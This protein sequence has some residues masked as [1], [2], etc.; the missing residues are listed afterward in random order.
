MLKFS[1]KQKIF[2]GY[3]ILI[4]IILALGLAAFL[5]IQR[6]F[7]I[8]ENL[9][10]Q[11]RGIA[12]LY[13]LEAHLGLLSSE[14]SARGTT[15][16]KSSFEKLSD[17]F[18]SAKHAF[19][20]YEAINCSA[21]SADVLPKIDEMTADVNKEM[22]ELSVEFARLSSLFGANQADSLAPTIQKMIEIIDDVTETDIGELIEFQDQVIQSAQKNQQSIIG[23][24][25]LFIIF[26]I[27]AGLIAGILI[28][29]LI[30][31]SVGRLLSQSLDRLIEATGALIHS[32]GSS[33][34]LSQQNMSLASEIAQGADRQAKEAGEI[35]KAMSQMASAIHQASEATQEVSQ[36]ATRT[37]QMA[38]I[39]GEAGEKS[40]RSLVKIRDIVSASSGMIKNLSARS[41]EIASIM[42][43][44]TNIAEQTNLLALNAAIEAARAGDA[45]RG[46]AVVADEVRKL[47]EEAQKSS[48]QIKAVIKNMQEQISDIVQSV[49]T[50]AKE[51]DVGAGVID[52]TLNTLQSITSAIQQVSSKIQ[53]ISASSQQQASSS[54]QVSKTMES[55]VAIIDKNSWTSNEMKRSAEDQT[56]L[57]QNVQLWAEKLKTLSGDFSHIVGETGRDGHFH[58]MEAT[59]EAREDV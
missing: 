42:E 30:T 19:E 37:S 17:H 16:N 22:K 11:T 26:G 45:G 34:K 57:S 4:V 49:D 2:S 6:L 8:Q 48:A 15:L 28:G 52:E 50:G 35:S 24:A 54:E 31:G 43:V 46:F 29:W 25:K 18:A 12:D 5:S 10:S 3:I 47:A 59:N 21:V 55:I 44:I 7:V 56:R 1:L 33:S 23:I 36:V 41:T 27:L 39:G 53:E 14:L 40:T 20:K 38:Q 51:V 32:A 9:H 58:E 13:Q